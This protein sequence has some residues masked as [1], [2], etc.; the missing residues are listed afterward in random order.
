MTT[1]SCNKGIILA[2]GSGTRLLSGHPGRQQATAAGLRQADDLLSAVDADAGR[3]PRF[4]LIS[5]PR[6]SAGLSSG[7]WATAANWA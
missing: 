2:G 5:T 3:H 1:G 7:C 4:L 6:R